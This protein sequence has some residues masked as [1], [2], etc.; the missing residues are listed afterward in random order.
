MTHFATAPSTKNPTMT[1][2]L[3]IGMSGFVDDNSSQSNCHPRQRGSLIARA[4]H[5]AQLWSD[6]LYSSGGVLEH[7]KCSYHYMCTDFDTH[8][9]PILRA[10]IHGDPNI[11]H[12]HNNNPTQ[13]KQ[14]SVYTPYKTLGTFQCPGSNQRGQAEALIKR[15]KA[16]TRTLAT[17]NCHGPSAWLFFNSVFSKSVGYPLAVSRL[18][19]KHLH[20]IQGPMIPLILNR[21]GYERRLARSLALGPRHFGGLG[22]PHLQSSKISSQI[23]LYATSVRPANHIFSHDSTSPDSSRLQAPVHPSSNLPLSV[24]LTLK[25][26]G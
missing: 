5:N 21:L 24:Y 25:D 3:T 4:T 13:L 7:N 22:I 23:S 8:G 20:Q 16:L 12:D 14:L 18:S 15:S 26:L 6:I 1:L 10:G 19:P 9:A 2:F 11:I 17:S